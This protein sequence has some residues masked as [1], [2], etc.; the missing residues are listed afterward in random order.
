MIEVS[1]TLRVYSEIYIKDP[2]IGLVG[3][4]YYTD[5]T[6]VII[7]SPTSL[8]MDA[9]INLN[10][11]NSNHNPIGS[12][13]TI[14]NR[15]MPPTG[16]LRA[17]FVGTTTNINNLIPVDHELTVHNLYLNS[18]HANN[19]I[20]PAFYEFELIK[21]GSVSDA[22]NQFGFDIILN[23]K[24]QVGTYVIEY[25]YYDT[26][27][28][29]SITFKKSAATSVSIAN[30]MYETYSSDQ[31]GQSFGFETQTADFKTYVEFGYLFGELTS[32]NNPL[33]FVP[34]YNEEAYSYED[35]LLYYTIRL[36]TR[37]IMDDFKLAPYLR[38]VS[39]NMTY[40]YITSGIVETDP[41]LTAIDIGKKQYVITYVV[42]LETSATQTL[43]HI[44]EERTPQ[45]MLVYSDDNLLTSTSFDITREALE[46]RVDIDFNLIE[47]SMYQQIKVYQDGILIDG[48]FDESSGAVNEVYFGDNIELFN[49]IL[50]ANLDIGN[51]EY[52]FV[53][54]REN[55]QYS[56]GVLNIN[57]LQGVSAYLLD[58]KYSLSDD[59]AL[60]EYPIIRAANNLGV[61]N[62]D[63][64]TRIYYNGVDYHTAIDA[65]ITHFRVDGKVA[66]IVLENYAPR[67]TQ[68]FGSTIYRYIGT[69]N[70]ESDYNDPSKWSETLE[71]DYVGFDD[72]E[73]IVVYMVISEDQ[74]HRVYYHMTAT[75]IDYNLTLKFIIYYEYEDEF[76]QIQHILANHPNS[77][78]KKFSRIDIT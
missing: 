40:R 46:T 29:R 53:L 62:H 68:P 13:L 59:E 70:P 28:K 35:N 34:T 16:N 56:L 37:D 39:A 69:G 26:S 42:E 50:T 52:E 73:T 54:E 15:Q 49:L 23:D 12:A 32:G 2:G 30:L 10:N 33:T 25:S 45:E 1:F 75:D 60:L 21:K 55:V 22:P 63:Y 6:I 7:K 71:A 11:I 72:S 61:A 78:I 74:N 8:S 58:I 41:T 48:I 66:D 27:A 5:Y 57:K 43:V 3:D 24:L 17:L 67:L 36:G 65:G 9:I 14:T 31:E 38:L 4:K 51:K 20:D 18:I 44:I 64:D 47:F 76:G 77:P 19:S